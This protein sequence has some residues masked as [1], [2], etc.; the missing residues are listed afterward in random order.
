[1]FIRVFITFNEFSRLRNLRCSLHILLLCIWLTLSQV[2]WNLTW[3]QR[4]ALQNEWH[5]LAQWWLVGILQINSADLNRSF[6]WVKQT[7]NQLGHWWLTWTRRT[8]DT[9][10]FTR[11]HLEWNVLQSWLIIP[12][13]REWHVIK[14]DSSRQ[15][16]RRHILINQIRLRI[17]DF[18][19]TTHWHKSTCRKGH[20]HPTNNN[21]LHDNH[22]IIRKPGNLRQHLRLSTHHISNEIDGHNHQ[23]LPNKHEGRHDNWE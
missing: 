10:H 6:G 13:I 19:N 11:L 17:H 23:T 3:E 9:N 1:M 14:F 4:C 18:R 16:L 12:W 8:D 22:Q 15:I 5:R 20:H 21:G 7:W 2:I